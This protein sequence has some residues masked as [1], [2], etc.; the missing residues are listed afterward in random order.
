MR[1]NSFNRKL[2]R[3][4]AASLGA[5]A[6]AS[7]AS[8]INAAEADHEICAR[9]RFLNWLYFGPNGNVNNN[10]V[11]PTWINTGESQATKALKVFLSRGCTWANENMILTGRNL[12]NGQEITSGMYNANVN[13]LNTALRAEVPMDHEMKMARAGIYLKPANNVQDNKVKM[14]ILL[15][16]LTLRSY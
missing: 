9:I 10:N 6:F 15:I 3:A 4:L 13:A 7:S 2:R 16:R 8:I 14:D 1:R 12:N 5:F 11:N